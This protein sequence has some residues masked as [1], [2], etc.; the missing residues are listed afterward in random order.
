MARSVNLCVF[1][2]NLGR[3]AET[4]FT[5]SG[6]AKTKFSIATE[7]RWKDRDSGEWKSETDWIPVVLWRSENLANYLLKGQQVYVQ[8][9]MSVR[10]YD[11]KDGTKKWIT[12]I[13]ADVVNLLGGGKGEKHED[14]G[15]ADSGGASAPVDDV[16]F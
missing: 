1:V 8:G 5:P 16:P 3:D 9:R 13:V 10:S 15:G 7:R 12:E 14:G 11:D 4:T 2:G 6:T